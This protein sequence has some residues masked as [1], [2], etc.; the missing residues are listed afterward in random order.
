MMSTVV[1]E[2]VSEWR[3]ESGKRARLQEENASKSQIVSVLSVDEKVVERACY[4]NCCSTEFEV[5]EKFTKTVKNFPSAL[6]VRL[7][8]VSRGDW[9]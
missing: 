4:V 9:L 5:L 6:V 3:R 7:S 1:E 2:R 8:I